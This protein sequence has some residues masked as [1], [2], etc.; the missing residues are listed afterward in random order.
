MSNVLVVYAAYLGLNTITLWF[1]C[2]MFTLDIFEVKPPTLMQA[3]GISFVVEIFNHQPVFNTQ[4][5][6]KRLF[7]CVLLSVASAIACPLLKLMSSKAPRDIFTID[8]ERI[9]M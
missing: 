2:Y 5:L 9:V 3:L 7:I 8:G 6:Y 1:V 4:V